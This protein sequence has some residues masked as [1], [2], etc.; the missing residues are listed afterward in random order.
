MAGSGTFY[1]RYTVLELENMIIVPKKAVQD[2]EP[3]KTKASDQKVP[4]DGEEDN[5]I[6]VQKD[7]YVN[8]LID[9]NIIKRYV[10]CGPTNGTDICILDGLTPGQLVVVDDRLSIKIPGEPE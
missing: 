4:L 9:G 1:I 8:L 7:P 2:Y 5:E 10:T 6:S 3:K